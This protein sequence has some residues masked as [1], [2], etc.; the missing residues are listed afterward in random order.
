MCSHGGMRW[1]D[2]TIQVD[3]GAP[4]GLGRDDLVRT[5][6]TPEFAGITFHEVL[7]RS[8]LNPVPVSSA[9]PFASASTLSADAPTPAA[10]ASR[11]V[12]TQYPTSTPGRISTSRSSKFNA[13]VLR[14]EPHGGR[15]ARGRGRWGTN[16]DP[17]QRAEDGRYRLMPPVIGAPRLVGH[18]FSILTKERLG[19]RPAAAAT[20][21]RRPPTCR[22]RCHCRWSSGELA[23]QPTGAAPPRA[24]WRSFGRSPT[25]GWRRT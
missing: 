6:T 10:T 24:R 16:T 4:P 5:V 14:K 8:L 13:A 20:G 21:R 3:D 18:P 22:C 15:A 12:D 17:Y 2:Q 11:A 9:C 7:C 1:A 19:A 25:P 23:G